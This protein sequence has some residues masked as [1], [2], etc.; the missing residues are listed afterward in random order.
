MKEL[1]CKIC[2]VKFNS[3]GQQDAHMQGK[4]HKRKAAQT[5][6]G[7]EHKSN[8]PPKKKVIIT[9]IF[10]LTSIFVK[11]RG[12][13]DDDDDEQPVLLNPPVPIPQDEERT[14]NFIDKET[15]VCQ[16]ITIRS[17]FSL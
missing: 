11:M 13:E 16:L 17:K 10:G 1:L 8:K 7:D 6:G 3:Q 2:K 5:N 4:K 14:V 15:A 12:F 9:L